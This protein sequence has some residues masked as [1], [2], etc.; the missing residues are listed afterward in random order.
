MQL[1]YYPVEKLKKEV[2]EIVGQEIDLN[3]YQVFF[4]GSRVKNGG[5]ERSDV[6][7]G[8]EGSEPV[9]IEKFLNIQEK[10]ENLPTL[11]KIEVV[12]F[13]RVFPVFREVARQHIE[14]LQ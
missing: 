13:C 1:K 3:K 5:T 8:I 7:V 4:F 14:F 11:Y 10:I 6:D 9:P 12:D 2:L